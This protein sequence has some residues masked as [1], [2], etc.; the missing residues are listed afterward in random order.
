M[1]SSSSGLYV[2]PQ[3]NSSRAV[4]ISLEFKQ[5][6]FSP[7]AQSFDEADREARREAYRAGRTHFRAVLPAKRADGRIVGRVAA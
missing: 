7:F 6:S 2:C 1:R 5:T 3:P 4:A